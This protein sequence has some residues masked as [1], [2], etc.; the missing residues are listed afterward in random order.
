MKR[1]LIALSAAAL[2]PF[3]ASANEL[4]YSFVELG[5]AGVDSSVDASGAAVR[6]SVA[7]GDSFYLHGAYKD[8]RTER[9]GM[10]ARRL[11]VEE[12]NLGAGYRLAIGAST[13]LISELSYQELRVMGQTG[14]GWIAEVGVRSALASNFELRATGGYDRFEGRGKGF[15]RL[16]G[17]L[18]F[19]PNWGLSADAK[20]IDGDVEYFVGARLSF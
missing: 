12:W 15:A 20:L 4:S 5:Y 1:T 6:G 8:L 11:S 13:D 7:V 19:N 17:V 9:I 3:A 2:L 10:F 14:D 16:G 18:K